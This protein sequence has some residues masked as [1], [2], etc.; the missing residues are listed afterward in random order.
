MSDI[1]LS[2]QVMLYGLAGVFSALALL[3]ITVKVVALIFPFK[4]NTENTEESEES[5]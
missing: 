3:Y 5:E 4:E 2:L 1:V